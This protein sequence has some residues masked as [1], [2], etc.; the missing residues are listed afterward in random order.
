M[1]NSQRDPR[2]DLEKEMKHQLKEQCRVLME[3]YW[4]KGVVCEC[5][6]YLAFPRLIATRRCCTAQRSRG[7]MT[8]TAV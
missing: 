8:D 4:T 6:C 1:T 7:D 5:G 2:D 3:R